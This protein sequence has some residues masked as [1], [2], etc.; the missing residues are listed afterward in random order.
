MLSHKINDDIQLKMLDHRYVD[1]LFGLIDKNRAYLREWL[2]WVDGSISIE[3]T[4]SFVQSSLHLFAENNGFQLGVFYKDRIAGCI[5]LHYIDWANK[6]TSIG[7]WLAEE[8]QGRGLMTRACQAL[9]DYLFHDL[10]L[11]RVEIRAAVLNAKSRAIPERLQFAN[12]G[13]SRQAEWLYDYYVDHIIYG[14]LAVN[15]T[16]PRGGPS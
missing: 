7:Y 9:I 14:M 8:F 3:Q 6:K 1:E 5:G 2:P 4:K 12:E 16:K 10:A 11:N 15:W 13:T